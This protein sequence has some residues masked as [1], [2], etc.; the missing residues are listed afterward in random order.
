MHTAVVTEAELLAAGRDGRILD[1]AGGGIRRQVDGALL[2]RCCLELKDQIDPRGLRLSRAAITGPVDLAG[3]EVPFPLRFDGCEFG[4]AVLANGAQLRELALTDSVRLPGLVANGLQVRGDLDLSRSRVA[5]THPA[6]ASINRRAAIWLC[7]ADV[8]GLL[9]CLGTHITASGERAIQADRIRVGG[10]VRLAHD[11]TAFGE[12]RLLGARIGGSLDMGGA[13]IDS[14]A[15][16]ALDLGDAAIGGNLFITDDPSG[17]RA[18]IRGRLD[19]GSARISGQFLIR[20]ATLEGAHSAPAAHGYASSRR[21]GTAMSATRLSVGAELALEGTSEVTG[22][23]DLSMSELSTLS[24]GAQCSL[25]AAGRTALDLSHAELRSSLLLNGVTVE[26][27]LRV[28]GARI[29]GTFS[30]SGA[31]LSQPERTSLIAARGAAVDGD[32]ELEQ[33]QAS[34]GTLRFSNTTLSSVVA[35]GARLSNPG[36]VTVSLHQ[37]TVGGSVVLSGGFTSAGLVVLSRAVI[38]GRLECDQGS[39]DCPRPHEGNDQGHA[40]E[41]VSASVRGGMDLSW[42]RASPS[43]DLTDASTTFL[44]DDPGHWPGRILIAGFTYDRFEPSRQ[45][46]PA[47]AWDH[48]AR[49]VWLARQPAYDAGPY[50]QAARVF[51]RHG[52]TRAAESIL[53]AQRAQARQLIS[54]RGAGARRALDAVFGATVAYG[55]RPARVAWLLAVLLVLVLGSLEFPR[56]QAT[57]RASDPAGVVYTTA[58]AL[59]RAGQPADAGPA[60]RPDVCGGGQVRCFSPVLYT[61]D[62]VIPLVSLGQRSTWYPDPHTPDGSLVEWWL[63]AATLLGWLLSSILALSLARLARSS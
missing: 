27:T 20:N 57:L 37:A 42:S 2:R 19:M 22:G 13:R 18:I 41:A 50:E 3:L 12:V 15:R 35:T 7:E 36:D 44:A 47:R 58:G 56:T 43:V 40:I 38:A 5:G 39:F 10:T 9:L 51:R 30:L 26:G 29:H 55:Y 33:L 17:R 63:N 52:Y 46:D 21:T 54:G 23:L 59:P 14:P 53:I 62:T 31:R 28:S 16:T 60:A 8:G 11:F 48:R 32:L 34:G 25:R 6:S 24:V 4:S 1:C 45:G 49:S 61:I